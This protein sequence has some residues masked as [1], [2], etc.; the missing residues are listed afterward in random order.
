MKL[1]FGILLLLFGIF[2]TAGANII[3]ILNENLVGPLF[4]I[5][6]IMGIIGFGLTIEAL[7]KRK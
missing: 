1:T 7:D 3:L 6:V 5:G 4:W 2:F